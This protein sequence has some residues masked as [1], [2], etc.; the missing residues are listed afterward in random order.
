MFYNQ[1]EEINIE[2]STKYEILLLKDIHGYGDYLSWTQLPNDLEKLNI[3]L[4]KETNNTV[5]GWKLDYSDVK[6]DSIKIKYIS[7]NLKWMITVVDR[8]N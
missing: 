3:K 4:N 7:N 8:R 2:D 6:E 1:T 5:S